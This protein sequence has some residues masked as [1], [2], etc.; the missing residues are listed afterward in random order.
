[1]STD[2]GRE[3]A[4][5]AWPALVALALLLLAGR[6]VMVSLFADSVP[7]W[8]QW[9]AEGANLIMMD[10]RHVVKEGSHLEDHGTPGNLTAEESEQLNE[11]ENLLNQEAEN[12]EGPEDRSPGP[13]NSSD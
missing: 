10:G 13:S 7:F 8:D 6:V 12:Q 2:P 4:S 9:D 11:I 1:M 5:R 3:T